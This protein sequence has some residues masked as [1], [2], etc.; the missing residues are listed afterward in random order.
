MSPTGSRVNSLGKSGTTG[1][2][3]IL[4]QSLRL[5][6][7][8]SSL[9]LLGLSSQAPGLISKLGCFSGCLITTKEKEEIQ[10]TPR[11]FATVFGEHFTTA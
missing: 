8:S 5:P 1:D 10:R 9:E 4:T 11:G 7:P 3:Q 2:V 6:L